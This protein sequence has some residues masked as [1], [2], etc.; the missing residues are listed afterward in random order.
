L[1]SVGQIV[2]PGA[3]NQYEYF[4]S[5]SGGIKHENPIYGDVVFFVSKSGAW[6]TGI[7]VGSR[8]GRIYYLHAPGKDKHVMVS[9][10]SN[11]PYAYGNVSLL[12]MHKPRE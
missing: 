11:Q 6:H 8:E 7:Y 9:S 4:K 1:K 10:T 2:E 5:I 3:M 12:K